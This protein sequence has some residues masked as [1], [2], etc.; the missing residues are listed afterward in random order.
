VVLANIELAVVLLVEEVTRCPKGVRYALGLYYLLLGR[1][2]IL[3]SNSSKNALASV[4]LIEAFAL[5]SA[6]TSCLM[7]SDMPLRE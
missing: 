6:E 1:H 3:F 4:T 5:T 2:Y 7:L